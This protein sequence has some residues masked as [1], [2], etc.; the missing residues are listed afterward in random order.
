MPNYKEK[1]IA[2]PALAVGD[3]LEYEI[4][5]RLVT[6]FAPGEF[7]FAHNF[8]VSA[9]VRDERLEISVPENR[10]VIL[11][12]AAGAPYETQ[13]AGGR[14]IYLWKHAN[15]SLASDDSVK[16]QP[17]MGKTKPA[18]VEL[19]TFTGWEA[20]ARWYAIAAQGRSE[21]TPEIRAKTKE[22]TQGATE[23]LAKV[24]ALYDYVSTNI[25]YVELPL[26]QGSW[27]PHTA[28]EVFS[29]Q[30]RRLAGQAHSAGGDAQSRGDFIG[31]GTHP[32]HAQSRRVRAIARAI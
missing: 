12:S 13:H 4:A 17:E 28:A 9:I 6:P 2:V 15:L 26:G 20:V 29:E 24:Q 30:I 7:W 3:T 31:R 5:T 25:R 1:Q 10:K 22:L 14:T 19:T 21:P 23:S 18:D 11:K 32:V 16:N 8:V 27:R